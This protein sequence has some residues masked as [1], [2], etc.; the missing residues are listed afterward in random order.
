[1]IEQT[2]QFLRTQLSNDPIL[3]LD[4]DEIIADN[5]HV[6]QGNSQ[7][8]GLYYSLINI[9][10]EP[11][12]K[13]RPNYDKING[14]LRRIEPPIILNLY[15]LFAFKLDNYNSSISKLSQLIGF[16]Q[17]N[18]W[19]KI[20]DAPFTSTQDFSPPLDKIVVELYNLNFEQINHIWECIGRQ[21]LSISC[22]QS[23]GSE[24]TKR[25][26]I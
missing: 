20:D 10:E 14:Q 7:A 1:M 15:I 23:E 9:E 21:S 26:P 19:F 6:L 3:D 18:K 8:E 16:F 13:N 4:P 17:T 2:L 22:I 11:S 25:C 5:M 24:S 12:L